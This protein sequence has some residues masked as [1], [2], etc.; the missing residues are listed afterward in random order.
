MNLENCPKCEDKLNTL[1]PSGRLICPSCK[2]V[3][4]KSVNQIKSNSVP[5]QKNEVIEKETEKKIS[6][7]SNQEINKDHKFIK[8]FFR[9]ESINT[10]GRI[11]FIIGFLTM[12]LGLGYDTTTCDYS[13]GIETGCTH[14][15]GLLNNRSN[16]V[17]FGGFLC[18]SGCVLFG[19]SSH[20]TQDKKD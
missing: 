7:S 17:N 8:I 16:I 10:T 6:F 12:L 13:Y 9:D 2:W 15:I 20:L 3:Q 14:N 5:E 1:Q 4:S 11:L 19:K 18:V